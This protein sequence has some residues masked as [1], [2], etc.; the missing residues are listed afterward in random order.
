MFRLNFGDAERLQEAMKNYEGN[1]EEA[2]N[3]VLHS[4]EV[5]ELVSNKIKRLMPVSG[6]HWRGKKPAAKTGKSLESL[7]GNLS[8]TVKNK[9]AY[10][11]LYFPNDGTNTKRH[12]GQQFFFERGG[13]T[14]QGEIVERCINKLITT[15][16]EGV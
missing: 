5:S 8:L 11:Y 1:T 16:E 7:Q 12:R 15:F 14:A 4:E 13:E 10:G 9:K 3:E 6:K 2:I